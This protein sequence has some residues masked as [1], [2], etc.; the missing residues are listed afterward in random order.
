MDIEAEKGGTKVRICGR[1]RER[2]VFC[3][4]FYIS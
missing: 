4:I 1:K 3:H 2:E